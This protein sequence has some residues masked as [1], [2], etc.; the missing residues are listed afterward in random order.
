V[1]GGRKRNGGGDGGKWGDWGAIGGDEGVRL[2]EGKRCE[3]MRDEGG[4]GE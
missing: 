3:G 4:R 2:V 1:G